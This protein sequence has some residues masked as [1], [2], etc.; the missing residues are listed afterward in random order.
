[1]SKR[2]EK[3]KSFSDSCRGIRQDPNRMKKIFQASLVDDFIQDS[4]KV[5]IEHDKSRDPRVRQRVSENIEYSKTISKTVADSSSRTEF[6]RTV[7]TLKTAK[8][9][10]KDFYSSS[11]FFSIPRGKTSLN[12]N[13]FECYSSGTVLRDDDELINSF[14]ALSTTSE[15]DRTSGSET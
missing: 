13:Y 4:R 10:E 12:D 6:N 14:E 7:K 8:K 9:K 15:S 3:K 5:I 1:M 2:T 11:S